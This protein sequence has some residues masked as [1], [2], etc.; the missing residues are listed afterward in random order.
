MWKLFISLAFMLREKLCSKVLWGIS[1]L[2]VCA[3]VYKLEVSQGWGYQRSLLFVHSNNWEDVFGSTVLPVGLA[4]H[5]SLRG[6]KK[7]K[8]EDTKNSIASMHPCATMKG[9]P[10]APQRALA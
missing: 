2:S 8:Q 10:A 9:L 6:A 5:G 1:G 3:H 7:K 4:L